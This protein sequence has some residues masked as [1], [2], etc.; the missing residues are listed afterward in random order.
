MLA[1]RPIAQCWMF[2]KLVVELLVS[3]VPNKGQEVGTRR[4]IVEPDDR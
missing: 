3:P 4:R 1:P 2:L